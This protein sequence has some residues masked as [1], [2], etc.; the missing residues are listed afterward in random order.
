MTNFAGTATID[1]GVLTPAGPCARRVLPGESCGFHE[2]PALPPLAPRPPQICECT[3]GFPE[4]DRHLA[5]RCLMCAKPLPTSLTAGKRS[6]E[7]L[8]KSLNGP[9]AGDD[10]PGLVREMTHYAGEYI[11]R[12]RPQGGAVAL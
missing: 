7:P 8:A 9:A 3:P 2:P 12:S 1:C 6:S 10:T 11:C 4:L 5:P